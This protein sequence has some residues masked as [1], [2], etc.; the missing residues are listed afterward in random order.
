MLIKAVI[1]FLLAMVVIAMAGNALTGGAITRAARK[2]LPFAQAKFCS[3]CG[4]PQIG[5][6]RCGCGGK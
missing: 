1:L 2:R 6:A 5:A 3:R 4:K